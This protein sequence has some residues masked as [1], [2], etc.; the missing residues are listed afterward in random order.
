MYHHTASHANTENT[1]YSYKPRRTFKSSRS[2]AIII[3]FY[4]FFSTVFTFLCYHKPFFCNHPSLP[5]YQIPD[6][7]SPQCLSAPAISTFHKNSP[8]SP[9]LSTPSWLALALFFHL[10][11]PL[12]T[13]L[14]GNLETTGSVGA[15]KER[16]S[17]CVKYSQPHDV[18]YRQKGSQR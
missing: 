17:Q 4:A 7:A 8:N 12:F 1:P 13:C 18:S 3:N 11:F 2:L 14:T 16:G 10:K 6:P 9:Y 15:K 5:K